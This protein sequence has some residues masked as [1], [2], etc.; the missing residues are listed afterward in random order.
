MF[1]EGKDAAGDGCG[2]E[3]GRC[4]AG[5]R[6]M[7]GKEEKD[8]EEEHVYGRRVLVGCSVY[9]RLCF[10]RFAIDVGRDADRCSVKD[11]P[12]F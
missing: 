6:M 1:V 8:E 3:G 10:D 5:W 4:R 7:G 12:K 11:W 2:G 9:F